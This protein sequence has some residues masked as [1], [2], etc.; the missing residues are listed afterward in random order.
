MSL[1]NIN[2]DMKILGGVARGRRSWRTCAALCCVLVAAATAVIST[3]GT[4][5]AATAP[6]AQLSFSPAAIKVGSPPEMTFM[7]QNVPSGSLLYLQESSDRGQQ[8]LTVDKTIA[9]QGTAKLAPLPKGVYQFRIVIAESGTA[10]AE[11]GT[12]TLT[13]TGSGGATPASVRSGSHIPWLDII[14]KPVWDAIIAIIV[15]WVISLI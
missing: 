10:L 4:A 11:S 2:Q 13:V 6:S 7:S 1:T 3:P 5:E 9:T 12:A 8:W 14:V 15:S